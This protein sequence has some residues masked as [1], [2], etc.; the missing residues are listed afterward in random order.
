MGSLLEPTE[1]NNILPETIL[2]FS[3]FKI[4]LAICTVMHYRSRNGINLG[5][6]PIIT[7]SRT[8]GLHK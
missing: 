2:V 1:L 8:G 7:Y 5:L 3:P 4:A 6:K